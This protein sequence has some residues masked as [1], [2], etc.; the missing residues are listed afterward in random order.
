V[1]KRDDPN[2]AMS[3]DLHAVTGN[4]LYMTRELVSTDYAAIFRRITDQAS[5]LSNNNNNNNNNQ[6]NNNNNN[7]ITLQFNESEDLVIAVLENL[8]VA[9]ETKAERFEDHSHSKAVRRSL[10]STI[11]I[12]IS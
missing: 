7:N 3:C 6:N 12:V 4:L 2:E 11:C 10:V 8:F 9:L 1:H 5:S